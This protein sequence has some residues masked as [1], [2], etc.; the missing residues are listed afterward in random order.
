VVLLAI[1][2][3]EAPSIQESTS[4]AKS[5]APLKWIN[6]ISD[7]L[8]QL[9]KLKLDDKISYVLERLEWN[10][11]VGKFNLFYKLYLRYIKRAVADLPLLDVAWANRIAR[12]NYIPSLYPGK[13]TLFFSTDRDQDLEPD[14]NLGWNN[15]VTGGVELHECPGTHTTVMQ[16]PNVRVMAEKLTLCLQQAQKD[17][18]GNKLK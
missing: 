4:V 10:F 6:T 2:D 13:L 14:D 3:T 11:T 9:S 8:L 5:A 1:F 7:H 16:E 17:P 12:T 18:V 15:I